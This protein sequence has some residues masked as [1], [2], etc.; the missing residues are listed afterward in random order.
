MK[1]HPIEKRRARL[2]GFDTADGRFELDK[3]SKK[4]DGSPGREQHGF[5]PLTA[6]AD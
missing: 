4:F 1:T 5:P 6:M 3:T 2:Q